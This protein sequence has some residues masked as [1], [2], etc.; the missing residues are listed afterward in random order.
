MDTIKLIQQVK[1]LNGTELHLKAGSHPLMRQ[2]KFLRKIEAPKVQ[3]EDMQALVNQLLNE[4]DKQKFLKDGWFESNFFDETECNF[5]LCLMQA[6]ENQ[7]AII[8]IIANQCPALDDVS[9]PKVLYPAIESNKGF[10]ILSG[11]SHSGISTTLA[12]IIEHIN[13]KFSKHILIIEDPI[14]FNHKSK[15]SLITQR[16]SGKDITVLEQAISFANRMDVDALIIADIK[17]DPPFKRIIDYI[18][19]G[20]FVILSLS[21]L[22]VVS[23]F[24][25]ILL[26]FPP[27][28]REHACTIMSEHFLGALSQVLLPDTRSKSFEPVQEILTPNKAVETIIQKNKLSQIEPNISSAGDGSQIFA[29]HIKML[30]DSNR[31]DRSAAEAFLE[32]YKNMRG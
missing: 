12:A 7:I 14:E 8:K 1:N 19:G 18:A 9:F 32:F 23:T 5:R 30:L 2:N 17:K 4:E 22:G 11:P 6:Q 27:D 13:S 25:K 28:D 10:F 29:W 24:E 15:M 16:Q 26:S 31:I 3:S 21:T 20:N